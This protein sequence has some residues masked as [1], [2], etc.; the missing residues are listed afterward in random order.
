MLGQT[1]L[2]HRPHLRVD[3]AKHEVDS[4]PLAHDARAK[5]TE[6]ICIGKIGIAALGQLRLM[7]FGEKTIRQRTCIICAETRRVGPDWL[8]RS[9][10]APERRRI[11]TEMDVGCAG[12]LSNRYILVDVSKWM[13]LPR[14]ELF[15]GFGGHGARRNHY[16]PRP[17]RKL[18]TKSLFSQAARAAGKRA[19]FL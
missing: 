6:L 12:P 8:Q 16:A 5:A 11:D 18:K 2:I 19:D 9:V 3:D 7:R 10:Q 14:T 15:R 17:A 1:E 13:R 4:E